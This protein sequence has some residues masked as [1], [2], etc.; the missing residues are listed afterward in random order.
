MLI[1]GIESSCDETAAS[2]VKDGKE[3]LSSVIS[4]QIE[5]HKKYG[6]VVPEIAS[7]A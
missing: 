5:E 4:T 1:L 3:I 6:G 7:R 2:V